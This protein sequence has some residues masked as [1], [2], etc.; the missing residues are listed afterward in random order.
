[1]GADFACVQGKMMSVA[2][3]EGLKIQPNALDELIS[4]SQNDIRQVCIALLYLAVCT[5]ANRGRKE[6]VCAEPDCI[7]AYNGAKAMCAL[8]D[9]NTL[10]FNKND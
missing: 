8:G 3:R 9:I 6:I 5:A 10:F 2:F 7:N 4:A 1:M